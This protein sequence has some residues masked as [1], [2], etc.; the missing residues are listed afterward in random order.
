MGVPHSK[1]RY[2]T[3]EHQQADTGSAV[4]QRL[5]GACAGRRGF[6]YETP[7]CGAEPD[8]DPTALA[9]RQYAPLR[10]ASP[11]SGRPDG[12]LGLEP[13]NPALGAPAR[14]LAPQSPAEDQS[15]SESPSSECDRSLPPTASAASVAACSCATRWGG[16]VLGS[17]GPMGT[18][19]PMPIGA[20]SGEA[21]G[22]A[23]LRQRRRRRAFRLQKARGAAAGGEAATGGDRRRTARRNGPRPVMWSPPSALRAHAWGR[24]G[25]PLRC[26]GHV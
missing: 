22:P 18:M 15:H 5:K 21:A 19:D 8:T 24:A 2:R 20:T 6:P 17:C 3:L 23:V 25:R 11:A 13:C 12:P 4:A 14:L 7:G 16:G 1:K 9:P 26:L 10:H